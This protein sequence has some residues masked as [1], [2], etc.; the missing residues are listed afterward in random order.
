M[1]VLRRHAKT[2]RNNERSTGWEALRLINPCVHQ[3]EK[4]G[5]FTAFMNVPSIH[6]FSWKYIRR[7]GRWCRVGFLFFLLCWKNTN[8][9]FF[10]PFYFFQEKCQ[11]VCYLPVLHF[12]YPVGLW[13][14]LHGDQRV[15]QLQMDSVHREGARTATRLGKAC[16][17]LQLYWSPVSSYTGLIITI[18]ETLPA[19]WLW[20]WSTGQHF[21]GGATKTP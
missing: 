11:S 3:L 15:L 9:C 12:G 2:L 21:I 17:G 16:T 1:R 13:W 4:L 10:F 14:A 6:K 19:C 7:S 18:F 5:W 20:R 8:Q